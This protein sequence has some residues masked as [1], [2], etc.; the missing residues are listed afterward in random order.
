[1]LRQFTLEK[2]TAEDIPAADAM[3]RVSWLTACPNEEADVS[4]EWIE[5]HLATIYSP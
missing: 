3:R 5:A 1:M 2:M 4:R